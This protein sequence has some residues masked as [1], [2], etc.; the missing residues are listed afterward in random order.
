M[1]IR[2]PFDNNYVKTDQFGVESTI[3]SPCG[4]EGLLNINSEVRLSPADNTKSGL[5]TVNTLENIQV[6][7]QP[8]TQEG[9]KE[10]IPFPDLPENPEILLPQLPQPEEPGSL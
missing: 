6:H 5:L 2:G 8:C 10:P 3:W 4:L 7:W 9:E 1:T